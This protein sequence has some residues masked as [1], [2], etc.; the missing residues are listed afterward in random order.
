MFCEWY[1]VSSR[2]DALTLFMQRIG[3]LY[4]K[5]MNKSIKKEKEES[6]EYSTENQDNLTSVLL[7]R[8]SQYSF[9]Y[10]IRRETEN[11]NRPLHLSKIFSLFE[12]NKEDLYITEYSVGQ[13][14]LEQIFNQFAGTQDNPEN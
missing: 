2:A 14:T 12:E 1:I 7:E 8:P 13:T 3:S 10:R 4:T 5:E 9:R 11:S 6:K